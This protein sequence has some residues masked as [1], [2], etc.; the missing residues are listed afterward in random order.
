MFDA[1]VA[2]TLEFGL[3]SVFA[4][5]RIRLNFSI[6]DTEAEGSYYFRFLPA[7]STQNLGSLAGVDYQGYEIDATIRATDNFDL[8]LSYGST[9]S[10]ITASAISAYIGNHA[11]LVTEDTFNVTGQYHVPLGGS[12]LELV[13]RGDYQ[14]IGDT[15]WDPE[16]TTVRTPVNLLDVRVGVRADDWSVMAWGRNVHD[17]HYNT[18]WSPGG[19]VFKGKPARYGV[20]FTKRF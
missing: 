12:G 18:E 9:D 1:E 2:D 13:V 8:M 5:G 10:E 15:W 19:F 17:V 16:N 3:K 6:F 7:S 4:D 20:D 11:P 14:R